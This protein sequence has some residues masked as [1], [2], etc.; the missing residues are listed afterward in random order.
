LFAACD[1]PKDKSEKFVIKASDNKYISLDLNNFTL[2]ANQDDKAHAEVFEKVIT[3]EGK[4][5]IRTSKGKY[6]SA[7]LGKENKLIADREKPSD[8]EY[9]EFVPADQGTVHI[10]SFNGKYICSDQSKGNVLYADKDHARE[11]ETF[12]LEQQ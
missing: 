7:D 6:V 2:V 11:W 3:P 1:N 8:W 4:T 5:T 9:F 12:K 10:K